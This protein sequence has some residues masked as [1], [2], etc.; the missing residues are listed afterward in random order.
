MADKDNE[1]KLTDEQ[2]NLLAASFLPVIRAFYAS[3]EGKKFWEEHL[4]EMEAG[5]NAKE[6][7]D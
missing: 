1:I 7:T 4:K 5:I 2:L 6:G 3:E